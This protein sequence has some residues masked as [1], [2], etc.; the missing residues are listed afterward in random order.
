MGFLTAI[1]KAVSSVFSWLTKR[2]QEEN[3]PDMKANAQAATDAQIQAQ[4][5]KDINGGDLDKI[6]KDAAP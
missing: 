3:T 4:A 6:R 2:S 5:A 1:F